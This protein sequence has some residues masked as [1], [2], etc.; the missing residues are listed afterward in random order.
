MK[1]KALLF[2]IVIARLQ[3]Y[4]CPVCERNKPKALQGITHGSGPDSNWDYV[5]VAVMTVIAILT[6]V[7]SI[8]WLIRPNEKNANHIKYSFLNE[9]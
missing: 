8:K 3:A 2:L 6:L 1:K 5:I 9:Q 7:Y 4:G